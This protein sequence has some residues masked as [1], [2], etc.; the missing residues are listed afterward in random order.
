MQD[1]SW[2][3]IA[4]HNL[5]SNKDIDKTCVFI[6]WNILKKQEIQILGPQLMTLDLHIV[7]N[8]LFR[9]QKTVTGF[10]CFCPVTFDGL[11]RRKWPWII[12]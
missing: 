11:I 9:P 10:E 3:W 7:N 4:G 6:Y 5:N 12:K 8:K 2:K 1:I